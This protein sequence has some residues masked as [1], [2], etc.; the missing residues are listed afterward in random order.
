M[1]KCKNLCMCYENHTVLCNLSF[2]VK[3][4]EFL[5]IVGENGSGKSTLVKGILGLLKHKG[6]LEL[7]NVKRSEIGYLPQHTPVSEDFPVTAGEVVLSGCLNGMGFLPFYKDKQREKTRVALEKLRVSELEKRRFRDLSGGQKQRILIARALCAA[8]KLLLLDEPATG[9]DPVVRAELY[10]LI[11]VLH[12]NEDMTVIMVTH[13][14]AGAVANA[15]KILHISDKEDHGFFGMV[16]E[17]KQTT[18][19]KEMVGA[20]APTGA[21]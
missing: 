16:E 18:L 15:D 2:S 5:T 8:E 19:Y 1:I 9:L 14:L 7:T 20:D 12:K 17:Y 6:G 11:G 4:G 21:I 3:R 13:D 10:E